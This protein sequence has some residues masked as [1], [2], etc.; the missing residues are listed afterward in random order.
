L[1]G[2]VAVQLDPCDSQLGAD[3]AE[4]GRLNPVN[5]AKGTFV[6]TPQL[7]PAS[8]SGLEVFESQGK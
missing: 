6:D 7:D 3:L 8:P 2:N 1:T 4:V 5:I